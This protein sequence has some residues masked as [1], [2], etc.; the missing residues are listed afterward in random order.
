VLR[1]HARSI[2]AE[3]A[4][5]LAGARER[6]VRTIPVT[7]ETDRLHIDLHMDSLNHRVPKNLDEAER[8]RLYKI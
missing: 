5:H 3:P 6:S 7:R 2:E 1:C 4:A 8:N